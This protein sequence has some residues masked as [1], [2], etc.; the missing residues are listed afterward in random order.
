MERR[1]GDVEWSDRLSS[2]SLGLSPFGLCVLFDSASISS[3]H[4]QYIDQ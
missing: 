3:Y 2:G 1:G 4:F